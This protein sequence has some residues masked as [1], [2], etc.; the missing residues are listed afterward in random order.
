MTNLW[1]RI[2]LGLM[3]LLMLVTSVPAY[4]SPDINPELANS[5]ELT[6]LG[7]SF[8][9]RQLAI[10]TLAIVCAA[11]GRKRAVALGALAI[12]IFAALDAVGLYLMKGVIDSRVINSLVFVVLSVVILALALRFAKRTNTT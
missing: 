6:S 12:L 9:N 5:G 11:S 3:G 8:L 7:L 1:V 2:I 4:F 10:A